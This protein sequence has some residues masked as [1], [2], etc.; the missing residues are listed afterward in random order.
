MDEKTAKEIIGN[1]TISIDG[2]L[3]NLGGYLGWTPG[4][5]E[6]VLDG[7]FTA[8]QL[9]AIAWWMRNHPAR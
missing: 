4:D 6:A 9:E 3:Y 8:D 2:G 5:D 1:E 7:H